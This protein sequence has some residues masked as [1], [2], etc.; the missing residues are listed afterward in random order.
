MNKNIKHVLLSAWLFTLPSMA[1]LPS[2]TFAHGDESHD[3]APAVAVGNSPQR[4]PNG[5]VLLPKPSQRQLAVRTIVAEQ[6]DSPQ[7]V[8][9]SG[10]VIADPNASGRV[11]PTLSGR[12]EAGPKGLPSLGQKVQKGE[13]L[14]YVKPATNPIDRAN[15]SAQASELRANKAVAEKRLARLQQLEGTIP[16]KDIESAR[17]E[18]QSLTERLSTV[19]ASLSST[20]SLFAPASGVIASVNAVPGQVVDAR[21]VL[22]EIVDTSKL[23]IEA[24]AYDTQL[25][26]NIASANASTTA[27]NAISLEFIGAGGLLREQAI[28]IQF[29]IKPSDKPTFLSVGQPVKVLVQT[30]TKITGIP[31]PALAVVKNASNQDI[32]WV[33][34]EPEIFI[35]KVVHFVALDG[36]NVTV[37]D[38]LKV[39]DRIVV[40][41]ASLLN[42]VR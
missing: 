42:Q 2:M 13:L 12:L 25:A 37:T 14:A 4:L 35:A 33:H 27:G 24:L 18:L 23:R 28:P 41:G 16:Q 19:G 21:E 20:E 29:K 40:Q 36:A 22:F 6:K 11:Q 7:T 26:G 17:Y 15:Q 10:K 32:V 8:E 34:G 5:S 1:L 3:V 9:L 39:G 31:I 30:N 38:G